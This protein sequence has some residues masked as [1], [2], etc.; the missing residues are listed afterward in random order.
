MHLKGK[1][2]RLDG[3]KRDRKWNLYFS[4]KKK[5]F[6]SDQPNVQKCQKRQFS[7]KIQGISDTKKELNEM[8]S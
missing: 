3:R 6:R 7:L 5:G 2:G 8:F 4:N 1:R